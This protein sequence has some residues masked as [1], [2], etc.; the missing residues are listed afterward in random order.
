[1]D[2]FPLLAI[3]LGLAMDAFAVAI[4]S[5]ILLGDV[6]RGQIFRLSFHFGL[7]QFLMPVAGWLA[8][9]TVQVWIAG[10]D[11]WAALALL[12]FV[13]GKA[14]YSAC[15]APAQRPAKGDPTRG[16]TLLL[17]SLA[18]SIDALAV[19]LSFAFLQVE[20]V[21]ASLIIGLV[22]AAMTGLGMILGSRLG[23]RF[24]RRME[25][26][27]GLVLIGIGLKIVFDHLS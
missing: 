21:Y 23:G 6:D 4:A 13:G 19:G 14:V 3:A 16:A 25:I 5:S 12:G 27:G 26:V 9:R 8:G 1:M 22:A 17:L 7:F 18:T 2:F 20:I 15:T 10:Y 24:G 11:H